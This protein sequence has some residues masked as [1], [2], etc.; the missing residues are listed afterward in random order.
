M[1]SWSTSSSPAPA[2]PAT[3]VMVAPTQRPGHGHDD[4]ADVV[5]DPVAPLCRDHLHQPTAGRHHPAGLGQQP[6]GS[7]TSWS[8]QTIAVL[9]SV[10]EVGVGTGAVMIALRERGHPVVG[11]D[12]SP[13]MLALAQ[14]RLGLGVAVAAGFAPG[15][16]K[17]SRPAPPNRA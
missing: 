2:A 7:G 15:A 12:L 14:P 13:A 16:L 5:R 4:V 3:R 6:T 8:T 1:V 11:V 10:L 17:I 9:G